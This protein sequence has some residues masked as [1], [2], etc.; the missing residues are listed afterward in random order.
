MKRFPSCARFLFMRSKKKVFKCG[1][2]E[3]EMGF[4]KDFYVNGKK[5]KKGGQKIKQN[6]FFLFIL[7]IMIDNSDLFKFYRL[8]YIV[9]CVCVLLLMH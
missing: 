3:W 5:T 8:N 2:S 9:L 7:S 1:N 6:K 4:C